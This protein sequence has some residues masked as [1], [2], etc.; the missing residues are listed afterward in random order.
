MNIKSR[1][2]FGLIGTLLVVL[3]LVLVNGTSQAASLNTFRKSQAAYKVTK[4]IM[5]YGSSR[6]GAVLNNK[7]KPE[8]IVVHYVGNPN[9]TA[10]GNANWFSMCNN[11]NVRKYQSTNGTVVYDVKSPGK[12]WKDIGK[13]AVS[14][15]YVVG[16]KGEVIQCVPDNERAVHANT[17]Y[18]QRSIGIET[19]HVDSKGNYTQET[20]TTTVRLV[21]ALAK[22]YNIPQ[23]KIIRHYD[24][25]GK[26]CPALFAGEKN[27]KWDKF[28]SDVNAV[29]TGKVK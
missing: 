26:N 16:L 6:S 1:K 14:A 5:P 4:S 24:V 18:N 20:Y 21:A 17:Y 7:G 9:T 13:C 11:G 29:R 22:K 10:K 19:C 3:S 8:Y 15:H 23:K 25:T 27:A 12:G 28:L 2:A